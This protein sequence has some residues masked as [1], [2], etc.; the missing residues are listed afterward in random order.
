M[1]SFR[2]HLSPREYRELM[3]DLP[4]D[5][6]DEWDLRTKPGAASGRLD[7]VDRHVADSRR[8]PEKKQG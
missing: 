6:D 4:P 7:F 5:S 8:N 1:K 3:V 2:A